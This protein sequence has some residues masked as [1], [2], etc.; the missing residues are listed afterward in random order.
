MKLRVRSVTVPGVLVVM[1]LLLSGCFYSS[2]RYHMSKDP[3][4][5]PWWCHS[6]MGHDD[7][8]GE[9]GHGD[10]GHEHYEGVQKGM[11]S[12]S[13]CLA[14]SQH[15]D[16]ALEFAQQF[17]TLGEAEAAGWVRTVNYATGMGTHHRNPNTGILP[18]P[19][20]FNPDEPT[21]LQYD[22]NG[23]NAKLVGMSWYVNSGPTPPAG[24][25]G[26]NDWWHVHPQLCLSSST[27]LVIR[28]GPCQPGDN[29]TTIDLSNYWMVHAWI[30]P[31]WTYKPDIFINHHPCLLPGGPAGPDHECWAMARGESM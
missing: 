21:Y 9:G 3:D 6:H 28:D 2:A 7:H 18:A 24:F 12:W 14:L 15:L 30:V 29:G 22:G 4:T 25:P 26:D 17:P 20:V 31:G 23:A 19:G 10:H 11:L 27:G 5:R 1:T 13:D 8:E 16:N